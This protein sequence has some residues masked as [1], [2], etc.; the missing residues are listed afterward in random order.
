MR[1]AATPP[2]ALELDSV[3]AFHIGD[4][5]VLPEL[6]KQQGLDD[7]GFVVEN[8]IRGG[9]SF[10][11]RVR[12]RGIGGSYALKVP[13]ASLVADPAAMERFLDELRVWM[14]LSAC[15]GIVEALCVF[16]HEGRPAVVSR[17]MEGGSLRVKMTRREPAAFYDAILRVAGALEWAVTRQGVLHRDIK[18]ENVL[19]DDRGRPYVSDWGIAGFLEEGATGKRQ[20]P[21]AAVMK[22]KGVKARLIL[23]TITYASPEQLLGDVPV[24]HRAD[25]YSLGT[26]MYEWETGELPFTGSSWDELRRRKLLG[27]A[28]KPGGFL[29]KTAFGADE[30]IARCLARNPQD[31]YHDYRALTDALLAAAR[32]RGV[33]AARHFPRMRYRTELLDSTALQGRMSVH[34]YVAAGGTDGR[35]SNVQWEAARADVERAI[36]LEREEAWADAHALYARFFLP[37]LTKDLPDDPLQQALALGHARTLLRM[38]RPDEALKSLES[39]AGASVRPRE[40]V[41]LAVEACLL[42]GDAEQAER[43]AYAALAGRQNDAE[44]LDLLL[45]AQFTLGRDEDAIATARRRLLLEPDGETIRTLA[46]L[47]ERTAESLRESGRREAQQRF[48]EAVSLLRDEHVWPGTEEE[49]REALVAALVAAERWEEA[50]GEMSPEEEPAGSDE[51]ARRRAELRAKALLRAGRWDECLNRCE[52]WLRTFASNETLR[53]AAAEALAVGLASGLSVSGGRSAGEAAERVLAGALEKGTAGP[54]ELLSLARYLEWTDERPRA[55]QTLER[56]LKAFPSDPGLAVALA[57]ALERGGEAGQALAAAREAVRVAPFRPET[58]RA[59]AALRGAAGDAAGEQEDLRRAG[60][61][62]QEL[63]RIWT[64]SQPRT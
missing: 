40:A 50:L 3:P 7:H 60:E 28:P 11:A 52:K 63:A 19:F 35:R 58:W 21:P 48:A 42:K 45:K 62:E 5:V 53:R 61:I 36:A 27:E 15:E 4:V 22:G 24:D 8:V 55:I 16:R 34:G 9:M 59:L 2:S 56:G 51:R 13:N 64:A 33:A 43:L 37:A 41:V 25:I 18:P 39:L 10:C 46:A 17:W 14:T 47:L 20:A 23:G 32:E 12:P 31:R 49:R 57:R 38:G 44:L 6:A 26:I 29:R 1:G 30:V 54:S